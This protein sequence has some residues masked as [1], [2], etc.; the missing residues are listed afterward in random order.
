[1]SARDRLRKLFENFGI[2]IDIAD[3]SD[4]VVHAILAEY[5]KTGRMTEQRVREIIQEMEPPAPRI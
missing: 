2:K 1:M 5:D 3:L 4:D